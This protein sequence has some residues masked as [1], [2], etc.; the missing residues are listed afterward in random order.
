MI[1][2]DYLGFYMCYE[3]FKSQSYFYSV[4]DVQVFGEN[5]LR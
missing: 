2:A 4:T 3:I 1:E 5:G